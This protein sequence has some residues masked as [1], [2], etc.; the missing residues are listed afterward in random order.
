MRTLPTVEQLERFI[1]YDPETGIFTRVAFKQNRMKNLINK[2]TGSKSSNGYI[3]IVVNNVRYSAHKLAW[4]MYYGHYPNFYLD[5]CDGD[6]SNNAISNIR[7]STPSENQKNR[8]KNRNNSSGSNGVSRQPSGRWR[9]RVRVNGKLLS[10][11]TYNTYSE[12]CK[13]RKDYDI[14]NGF[15]LTHGVRESWQK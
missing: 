12:A 2:P 1:K 6:K 11:G 5:H 13:V 10:L 8:G 7:P 3:N 4:Y 14:L 9:V 15:S